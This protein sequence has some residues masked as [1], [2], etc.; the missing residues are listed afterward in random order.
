MKAEV[1]PDMSALARV[2]FVILAVL[3]PSCVTS[4]QVVKET[5]WK[6][7]LASGGAPDCPDH[8]GKRVLRSEVASIAGVQVVLTGTSV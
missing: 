6:P 5:D 4:A 2:G 8:F 1:R 7:P 3:F